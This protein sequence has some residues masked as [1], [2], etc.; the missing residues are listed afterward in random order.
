VD[1]QLQ[2]LVAAATQ[3]GTALSVAL[4]DLDFFKRIND[5]F[6]HG[7]GDQVLQQVAALLGNAVVEPALAARLGG[8]EF[9]LV[10]PGAD[11][12]AAFARCEELRETLR[13]H[14]WHELTGSLPVTASIGV[15]TYTGGTTSAS[16][17]L[18][19]ADRNL[20]AAKHAGRD[21]VVHDALDR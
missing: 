17:L 7:V 2:R 14:P 8:E 20:Y 4:V 3:D 9:L 15:T 1:E 12:A 11:P 16:T 6:S 19:L 13:R 18:S 5:T 21:R 10:L